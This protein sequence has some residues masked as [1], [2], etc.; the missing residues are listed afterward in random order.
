M[1]YIDDRAKAILET[2]LQN[3]G[4]LMSRMNPLS[5]SQLYDKLIGHFIEPLCEKPTFITGHP[6]CMS[7][8]A[9]PRSNKPFIADR[10]ELFYCGKELANG[11]SELNDPELQQDAFVQQAIDLQAGDVEAQPPDEEFVNVLQA[12]LPPTA[13]CGIGIDRL[14]MFLCGEK[15]IRDILAFPMIRPKARDMQLDSVKT[16]MDETA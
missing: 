1:S 16:N 9:K 12:G 6:V 4:I 10:F 8:L 7:P 5:L 13:G 15:H 2:I 11:F 3:Q 14:V